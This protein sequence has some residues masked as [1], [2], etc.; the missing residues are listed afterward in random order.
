MSVGG[1][2]MKLPFGG[3]TLQQLDSKLLI[4]VLA[5]VT[6]G[7][8]MIY[9]ASVNE[10]ELKH[11]DSLYFL[12]HQLMH[13]AF[14]MVTSLIV[15]QIPVVF[16]YRY[17]LL[18]LAV[19]VFLLLVVLIPGIGRSFHGSRRWLGVGPMTFQVSELA[20]I[21]MV[22][23]LAGYLQRHQQV[24]RDNWKEIGKP[25][26]IL[27]V[28]VGLLLLEPDLGSSVVLAGTAL[29]MLFF[30]GVKLWQVG[31]LVGLASSL[32]GLAALLSTYRLQRLLAYLDPWA[33]Q[34]GSGYQLTQ[35]LI[36][37]GRG[38][39]F[40][41]GLGNSIQKLGYLPEPQNDFIFAII[42]EELG[43]LGVS[44]VLGL[45]AFLLWRVFAIIRRA[46]RKC[47]WFSAYAVF[48]LGVL[49]AGQAFINIG[50]AS[51]L[52]PTKGL[53]LPFISYGGS[54]LL[55]SCVM[56]ALILRFG[57]E[58]SHPPVKKTAVKNKRAVR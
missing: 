58:L 25:L 53:T 49:L 57:M 13:I 47:D 6:L 3:D 9:S 16:W 29:G 4:A 1:P 45:F 41:V 31:V 44:V 30:A 55:V 26:G 8:V 39:F 37:F 17:G 43:L 42:A 11:S 50:V 22:L 36:A 52:L 15:L 20:K 5:L 12:K 34:F 2:T 14:A 51:G 40:G 10:A 19:A 35:S 21:A 24:L 48:G 54:S 46:V 7:L 27:T 38:E 32:L 18:L 33:D 56:V 28:L 23:F